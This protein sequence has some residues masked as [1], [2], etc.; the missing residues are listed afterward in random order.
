MWSA[1]HRGRA[2][3]HAFLAARSVAGGF[4]RVHSRCAL[5][6]LNPQSRQIPLS[7]FLTSRRTYQGL[8]LI[9]HSCTQASLQKVRRGRCTGVRHH[10]QIGRPESSR[11]GLPHWSAVTARARQVLT[12]GLSARKGSSSDRG[13]IQP[14]PRSGR[15]KIRLAL[16]P[17]SPQRHRGALESSCRHHVHRSGRGG[18]RGSCGGIV[19]LALR[20]KRTRNEEASAFSASAAVSVV[21]GAR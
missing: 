9:F 6:T 17:A 3:R 20:S 5:T 18:R 4:A 15:H 21:T 1:S 2:A 14:A 13:R 10:R 16:P 8:L 12:H 19:T 7:R 11:S